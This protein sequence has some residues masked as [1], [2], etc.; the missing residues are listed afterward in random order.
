M[1]IAV[2]GATGRTGRRV[3]RRSL[4]DGHHVTA[5]VRTPSKL[6]VNHDRLTVEQGDVTNYDSFADTLQGSDAVVS[7][8]GK[9][10]VLGRVSLYSDGITNIIQAMTEHDVSRLIAISSGGTYPGW[11]SNNAVFYELLIKRVLLR[12]VYADMKRMEDIVVETDLDWTIVRPSGLSDD[13]GSGNYRAT[14]GYSDPESSTT[15]RDDLAEFIVEE[16][17]SGQF[18]QQGV[19]VVTV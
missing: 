16:L 3:V 4:D 17:D 12:R 5:V 10:S 13:T 15:T 6:D 7:T 9:E 2:F 19:A 1:N 11:D 8:I 14:V 18:L